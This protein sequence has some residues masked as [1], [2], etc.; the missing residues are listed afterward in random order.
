MK[1][2]NYYMPTKVIFGP[3]RLDEIGKEA[4][5]IGS[6]AILVTGRR[7]MRK[8]GIT[9]RVEK[10]LKAAGVAIVPYEKAQPNPTV[11]TVDTGAKIV[12]EEK[13][14]LV[15]GLGGGSAIDTAKG[16]AIVATQGGSI[17]DYMEAGKKPEEV[18]E[19]TSKTLPIIAIPTTSGTGT[20]TSLYAVVT[21]T[22][23]KLK[24]GTGSPYLFPK[25]SIIDPELLVSMPPELTA[26]T[27]MDA[28]GHALE[29]Y[30]SKFANMATDNLATEALRLISASLRKAYRDGK[31]LKARADIAWGAALSGMVISQVDANL[32]HAMSHPLSAHYDIAHGLAVGLLTPVTMEYNIDALPDKYINVAKIMGEEI[33]E[34]PKKEAAKLAVKAVRRLLNDIGFP[35]GFKKIGVEERDLEKL[36]QDT[37]LMGALTTNI[38]EVKFEDI[39]NLFKKT[40]NLEG[41]RYDGKK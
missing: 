39:V 5:Q 20:E 22:E 29:G 36:A 13:C 8:F 10:L 4:K 38:K 16:I 24:E 11:A 9:E 6:K 28:F 17:W 7:A 18:K 14:D 32:C 27:G 35:K 41:V 30:T 12:I 34:L 15:I 37:L 19:I 21:N 26:Y 3:G 2:F 25:V 1:E 40:F 23:S 33:K 31:N